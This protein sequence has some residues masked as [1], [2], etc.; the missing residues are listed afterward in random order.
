MIL[1]ISKLVNL[2][3]YKH[4]FPLAALHAP[5]ATPRFMPQATDHVVQPRFGSLWTAWL[6]SS[7]NVTVGVW[8]EAFMI[9]SKRKSPLSVWNYPIK[10]DEFRNQKKMR[11]QW[12][13]CYLL[14]RIMASIKNDLQAYTG[15]SRVPH[16]DP[17]GQ[18]KKQLTDHHRPR[19]WRRFRKGKR[20]NITLSKGN[21]KSKKWISGWTHTL[22]MLVAASFEKVGEV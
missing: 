3:W 9:F 12:N 13:P 14:L 22:S 7:G 1:V 8:A 10:R 21:K 16:P 5:W 11:W 20:S 17:A 18:G 15:R 4:R 19:G 6:L 2:A